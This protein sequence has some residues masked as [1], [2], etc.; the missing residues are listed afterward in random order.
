MVR[1]LF[2]ILGLLSIGFGLEESENMQGSLL[3]KQNKADSSVEDK[4]F[5]NSAATQR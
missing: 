2:L 3:I 1:V 5:S 4:S